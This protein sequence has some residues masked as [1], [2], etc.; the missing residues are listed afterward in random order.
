VA[1][2]DY[3]VIGAGSAGCAAAGRLAESGDAEVVVLE[4]GGPDDHD[5]IHVPAGFPNLFRTEFDWDYAT[6]PQADL[7]GRADYWP[8]GRVYG[9]SGSINA[10]V[11]QRG[12]PGCYDG[13]AARGNPGWGWA[14]VLPVFKRLEHN[15]RGA[16]AWHGVGGPMNVADQRDPNPLSL[17]FVDAAAE[18]GHPRNDDFN[19]PSQ[20]GFGLFQVNQKDGLR[21][22]AARAY[23]HPVLGK[24]NVTAV[25]HAQ[26][27]RLV[28]DGS[29]CT[30]A[31]YRGADGDEHVASARRE[32]VLCGGAIGSP[33]LLLLS[34][35]GPRAQLEALGIAVV[36]D[37][38]G[39]GENLLDH[40]WVPVAQSCTQPITMA[41]ALDDAQVQRF[42]AER[43]GL[44]TSNIAEA[45]GFV[46]LDSGG[47]VPD[48][49]F[50][51]GALYYIL[52]GAVAPEGHGYSL[53]PGLVQPASR[54][55]LWLRSADPAAKPAIDP[56]SLSEADDVAVLV[57]GLK[58]A[59]SILA[60][61]AF[62]AFRGEEVVPGDGVVSDDDL[63]AYVRG[64][65][66][67]LFHPVGTCRMGDDPDAVVD[68][69]LRV[70]GLEG[71]R[72]ADASVM[73]TIVNANTN[74]PSIM[75]GERCAELLR[76]A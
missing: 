46:Q 33:Q 23:L 62:D 60:S 8:R 59:R 5:M 42:G 37:V 65:A 58:L 48:L 56:A 28:F 13:W 25:P 49:Q 31:V 18:Q 1:T 19:G 61:A 24:D 63:A 50:H 11:V 70:R 26:V 22:S 67:T 76:S 36:R 17:A 9:G 2:Y 38:P 51:F 45:G 39:V 21:W 41:A 57:E 44:L 4:A 32:V 47:A 6:E 10:Q 29:R 68:A 16:S 12:A 43:M 15:E 30:G 73:P 14:D 27:S 72:V 52:H 34:G 40:M 35:V 20:L 54:G 7:G 69:E 75:I 64:Y 3:V 71:L 55:R 53:F 74:F 66:H